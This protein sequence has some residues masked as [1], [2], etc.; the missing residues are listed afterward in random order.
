VSLQRDES[1]T[2]VDEE[3]SLTY[4]EEFFDPE[5]DLSQ[6]DVTP[7]ITPDVSPSGSPRGFKTPF[8]DMGYSRKKDFFSMVRDLKDLGPPL[9]SFD[10]P[11][12][13]GSPGPAMSVFST[14]AMV[15]VPLDAHHIVR[16]SEILHPIG[17][18]SRLSLTDNQVYGFQFHDWLNQ[19]IRQFGIESL[20]GRKRRFG[21]EIKSNK[22]KKQYTFSVTRKATSTQ[23]GALLRHIKETL[24]PISRVRVFIKR[25]KFE[26]I[27]G[28]RS[29]TDLHEFITKH[30]KSKR[31]VT[32]KL[33]W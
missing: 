28:I 26:A 8:S 20:Q 14:A 4:E 29:T 15:H 30:L 23:L 31:K 24:P 16:L 11:S 27:R 12:V 18:E 19:N 32:M 6:V 5:I 17:E 25:K 3:I 2:K 22:Y 33:S 13:Y 21:R 7:D 1:I 9:L 10:A